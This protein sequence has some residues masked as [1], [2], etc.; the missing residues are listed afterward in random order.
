MSFGKCLTVGNLGL[1][2]DSKIQTSQE[3]DLYRRLFSFQQPSMVRSIPGVKT[4]L[5]KASTV[6]SR[7]FCVED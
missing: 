7:L 6:T 3:N 1:Q 2:V 4:R 5:P